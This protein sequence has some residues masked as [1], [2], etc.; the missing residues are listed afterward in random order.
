MKIFL[1]GF[2]AM[3]IKLSR[4]ICF[5]IGYIEAIHVSLPVSHAESIPWVMSVVAGVVIYVA[6]QVVCQ[7]LEPWSL[8]VGFVQLICC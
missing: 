3:K 5:D 7:G 1:V 8:G 2:T 6:Y 4:L